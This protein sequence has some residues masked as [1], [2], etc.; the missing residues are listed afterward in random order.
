[1]AS[2][3]KGCEL[4]IEEAIGCAE[5]EGHWEVEGAQLSITRCGVLRIEVGEQ[6]TSPRTDGL[7]R[8]GLLGVAE[9][10]G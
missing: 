9:E 5:R 4:W 7:E 10:L 8:V 6:L 3:E 1:M 2:C